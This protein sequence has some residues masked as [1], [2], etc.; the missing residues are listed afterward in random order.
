MDSLCYQ[1]LTATLFELMSEI[2]APAFGQGR[3]PHGAPQ[4]FQIALLKRIQANDV[5][6]SD[7]I[8]TSQAPFDLP[9][10]SSSEEAEPC[11]H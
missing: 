10:L 4:R 6:N 7:S 5:F 11:V 3:N 1:L 2:I 9:G 8:E